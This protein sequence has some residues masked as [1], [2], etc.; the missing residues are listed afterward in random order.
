[1]VAPARALG[2]RSRLGAEVAK[3]FSSV[4]PPKYVRLVAA[5]M[6]EQELF[7]AVVRAMQ[8]RFL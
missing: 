8:I 2:C 4:Q 5:E 6:W 1:M 3:P 7:L